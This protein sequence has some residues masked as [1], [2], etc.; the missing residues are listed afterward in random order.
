MLGLQIRDLA[1]PPTLPWA[2]LDPA[3]DARVVVGD[4]RAT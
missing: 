3:D 2:L 4:L 1:A